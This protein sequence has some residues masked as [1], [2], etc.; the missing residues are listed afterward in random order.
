MPR[1][2]LPTVALCLAAAG[3][4][5]WIGPISGDDAPA[6]GRS[7][8]TETSGAVDVPLSTGAVA[9]TNLKAPDGFEVTIY[10]D[11]DLVHDA[12]CLTIDGGG[13]VAVSAPGYV[14]ILIDHNA[15]GRADEAIP[16]ANGPK[17]GAQGLC[18]DGTDLLAVG[19]TGLMRYRDADGDLQADGPPVTLLKLKAGGEHHAHAIRRGPDGAW[20]LICGNDTGVT[21][22]DVTDPASPV[23]DPEAG[24]LLRFKIDETGEIVSNLAVVADGMRN[25]YDFDF[26]A[27]R[28][29]V[30]YDSDDERE[31]SLPWYRPTRVFRLLPGSHAGWMSRSWKRADAF[32]E[33]PETLA[34]LGRGSP[35]GVEV[36][37]HDAFPPPYR[38]AV[39]VCDW[40]FGRVIAIPLDANGKPGEPIEFLRGTGSEGFAP[41]DFAVAPDGSVFISAGGRGT[42]GRVYRVRYVGGAAPAVGEDLG[43]ASAGSKGLVQ[44][45]AYESLIAGLV[46]PA[47]NIRKTAMHLVHGL[48]HAVQRDI[49]RLAAQAGPAA[50][51]R[52]HL[53]RLRR[54]REVDVVA[55]E[56]AVTVLESTDLAPELRYDAVR[57]A[58]L[59]LGDIGPA[60]RTAD[61]FSGYAARADLAEWEAKIDP[62]RERIVALFP[63]G[64]EAADEELVRL[65]A[66]LRPEDPALLGRVLDQITAESHPTGDLH[67]L[68]VI[69]RLPS[70]RYAS[71][72]RRT[73]DVLIGLDA[74]LAARRLNRD[75][76]WD[77]RLSD[78]FAAL[79]EADPDLPAAFV[80]HPEFGRPGHVAL[81]K[82][83]PP[84]LRAEAAEAV[85]QVAEADPEYRWT[86]ETVLLLGASDRSE[87][88]DR[89]RELY[90]DLTVRSDALVALAARPEEA[91]R[92]RFIE[93]LSEPLIDVVEA[94]VSALEALSPT[95]SAE[96]TAAMVGALK[97]L[98]RDAREYAA[99]DRVVK[100]LG[101]TVDGDFGF[102]SGRAGYRPQSEAVERWV[103]YA[104]AMTPERARPVAGDDWQAV[105][106]V[107]RGS[108]EPE[109]DPRRG[110]ALYEA[111]G[112]NRCHDGGAVGPDLA[113]VTGRFSRDDLFRAIADPDR[114]VS[115]RYRGTL[116]QTTDGRVVS[117]LVA[118]ESADGV[119]LKDGEKTW[120]FETDE[121]EFRRPLETSL[122]PRG[123]LK[124]LRSQDLADLEAYLRT[125]GR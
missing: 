94:C 30:T 47:P 80:R 60:E 119:T 75:T 63:T 5:W 110:R 28:D 1:H 98:D 76:N 27:G 89:L 107:V 61:T 72:T 77:E 93:G 62:L 91:D 34:S 125:V 35:T 2:V 71:A 74:K 92:E 105:R 43:A 59:A 8:E 78:L 50:L 90:E 122:M 103:E 42:N 106:T 32:P 79:G 56:T 111:K 16:F 101:R 88:R 108:G 48:P 22:A 17:T 115:S 123:L 9:A 52:F 87:A 25:A 12:S 46:D 55:L 14:R 31:V 102:V 15:D 124:D 57:L 67:H 64:D 40:T 18:F 86:A 112:C 23:L 13:R 118:Y 26:T 69:A 116:I 82:R 33:M 39:F 10:A 49:G 99:R 36:Y 97:R 51:V 41:T 120:R 65:L 38:D 109:G 6:S 45:T 83:A 95:G 84:S 85:L 29:P 21:A 121:I 68:F 73:A 11:D 104:A 70:V 20:Y 66:M 117:G 7:A 54:N 19:D 53:G 4:C 44:D 114:D 58:Q 96:E 3:V 113:G 81:L 100:L 24:V 37:R